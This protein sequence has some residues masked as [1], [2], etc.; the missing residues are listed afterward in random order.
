ML[1][2]RGSLSLATQY[3][4]Y[5]YKH[6]TQTPWEFFI[7]SLSQCCDTAW[8]KLQNDDYNLTDKEITD[9]QEYAYKKGDPDNFLP[10]IM[11]K[12]NSNKA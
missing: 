9:I 4:Y 11:D 5:K 10:I 8:I 12:Y 7:A 1:I 2:I 6:M 3:K